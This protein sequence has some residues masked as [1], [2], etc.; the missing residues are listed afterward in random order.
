ML[1]GAPG[2]N[3]A[4]SQHDLASSQQQTEKK[5][6]KTIPRFADISCRACV[7]HKC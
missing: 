3:Q 2:S 7:E 1:Y 5:Q 4:S 6:I